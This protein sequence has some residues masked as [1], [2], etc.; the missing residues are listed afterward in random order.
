LIQRNRVGVYRRLSALTPA[1]KTNPSRTV[2]LQRHDVLAVEATPSS[3]RG[4][5][6]PSYVAPLLPQRFQPFSAFS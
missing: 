6:L 4:C 5:L 1:I 2:L 3:S